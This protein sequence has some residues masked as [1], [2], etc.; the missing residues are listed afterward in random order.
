[1][2][3]KD[4]F[5]MEMGIFHVIHYT[6]SGGDYT[7]DNDA[8]DTLFY[9]LFCNRSLTAV[10]HDYVFN[11]ELSPIFAET[12]R[13]WFIQQYT[14]K[15]ETLISD[16]LMQYDPLSPVNYTLERSRSE[17]RSSEGSTESKVYGYNST[18]GVDKDKADSSNSGTTS[19][20]TEETRTGR[21]GKSKV[22]EDINEHIKL[23]EK[24][25]MKIMCYD[26][27]EFILLPMYECEEII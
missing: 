12:I 16:L 17:E 6:Y 1:M 14:Q 7:I 11:G 10:F 4:I 25:V 8:L 22:L 24:D 9:M 5:T 18:T 26:V 23:H 27:A 15:W 2:K 20:S 19:T 21:L 13:E 3:Y